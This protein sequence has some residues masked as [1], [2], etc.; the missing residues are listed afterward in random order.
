MNNKISIVLCT[1]NEVNYIEQTIK[2]VSKTLEGVEII[3]V[4]DNSVDGTIEKLNQLKKSLNFQLF[5]RKNEKGLASAI[6]K[7]FKECN[8]NFIGF[9]DVN[10]GDQ[11][12]YFNELISK[13]NEG[14][15]IAVLSRYI[16]GGGDKRDT[17]RV[18]TSK[19]INLV[20]KMIL[21][22]KFNDFTSGIFL[23]KK[24]VLNYVHID[25]KGHGEYFIEFIYR[26]FK[27]KFK[28]IEIPYVQNKDKNLSRS[29]SN[30]N[31]F[32]FFYLGFN[33]FFRILLT[34][35]RN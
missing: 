9:I 26:S 5:V 18:I 10:S 30:P 2:L 28:I 25:N 20:C 6:Q 32:R 15:D 12:L 17:L 24:D 8:G 16:S 35:F 31:I 33:Y 4:D 19:A 22:I 1:Y 23:M 14:Y 29:K 13:L 7:G 3:I 11:I 21:R 27:T 34:L